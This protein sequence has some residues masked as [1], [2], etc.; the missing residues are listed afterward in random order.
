M[1]HPNLNTKVKVINFLHKIPYILD[2]SKKARTKPERILRNTFFAAVVVSLFEQ[3][4]QAYQDKSEGSTDSVGKTWRDLDPK[5]K[6]YWKPEARKKYMSRNQKSKLKN[7]ETRGL[8]TKSQDKAWRKK[9]AEVMW[10][11]ESAGADDMDSKVKA[12]KIAWAVAKNM[13]AETLIDTL[14]EQRIPIMVESG[15][16]LKSLAPG[17]VHGRAAS[18]RGFKGKYKKAHK[19]QVAIYEKGTI[20]VGTNVEY[21]NAAAV[22]REFLPEDIDLWYD[23]A[24]EDASDAIHATIENLTR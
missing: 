16:L 5:T 13:G 19:N 21:A 17:K 15:T 24:V 9:F 1:P 23:I 3:I 22:L 2:G 11:A 12:A 20:E 18:K 7:R 10:K 4:H 6:A 14:G 8:L